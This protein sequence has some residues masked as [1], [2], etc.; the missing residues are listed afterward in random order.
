MDSET[1]EERIERLALVFIFIPASHL[2]Y[3]TG[4]ELLRTPISKFLETV[5]HAYAG[6]SS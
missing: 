4:K 6:I 2:A 3:M 1:L 5:I